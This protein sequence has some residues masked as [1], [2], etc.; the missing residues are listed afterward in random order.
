MGYSAVF[1]ILTNILIFIILDINYSKKIVIDM[2]FLSALFCTLMINV[3]LLLEGV[4]GLTN[5][6]FLIA[7]LNFV[8]ACYIR[9]DLINNKKGCK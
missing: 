5:I 4:G 6:S 1:S 8:Y 9:F 2:F 3:C 7:F